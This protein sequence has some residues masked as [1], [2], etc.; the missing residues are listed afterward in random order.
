MKNSENLQ[1]K[2]DLENNFFDNEEL[3][4]ISDFKE[5]GFIVSD[6]QNM[7]LL[8]ALSHEVTAILRNKLNLGSYFKS[9]NFLDLIHEYVKVSE[10]NALRLDLY[11]QL[12]SKEWFRPS[13]YKMG[14]KVLNAIVG[15]ELAMQNRIN[16]SIQMPNDNTSLLDIHADVFAGESP[17]QV[18]QW[19]AY[20]DWE[21][22]RK[23]VV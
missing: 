3:S 4:M 12:N 1:N 22:D 13:Y 2:M 19:S 20:R 11:R 7:G 21:T 16:P 23:S 18:V 8:N 10:V 15:N 14:S 6:V 5:N 17:Y 9:D